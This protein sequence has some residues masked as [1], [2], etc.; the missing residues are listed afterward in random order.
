MKGFA[1]D[2]EKNCFK[3]DAESRGK[4]SAKIFPMIKFTFLA[5][6]ENYLCVY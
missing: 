1:I 2:K 4:S 6:Q 5:L 3:Q